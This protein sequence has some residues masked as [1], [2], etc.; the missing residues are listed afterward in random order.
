VD[1]I[2]SERTVGP[3]GDR[4]V[5]RLL[6]A[7]VNFSIDFKMGRITSGDAPAD[8]ITLRQEAEEA[9][10]ASAREVEAITASCPIVVEEMVAGADD[11]AAR[12]RADAALD[13]M[14]APAEIPGLPDS[15]ESCDD[16]GSQA[17]SRELT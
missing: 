2:P 16:D 12:A 9:A 5:F 13:G 6:E 11:P 8:P 1:E 17:P 7:Y 15:G 14:R 4:R 10:G 3:M